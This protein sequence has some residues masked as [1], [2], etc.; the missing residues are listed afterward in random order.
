MAT[1]QMI[2]LA[3]YI[4]SY[5]KKVVTNSE[6]YEDGAEIYVVIVRF[7][8]TW[9]VNDSKDGRIS[10]TPGGGGI[11]CYTALTDDTK[12]SEMFTFIKSTVEINLDSEKRMAL[13]LEKK[14]VLTEI[15]LHYND[16]EKLKTIE[17]LVDG[18]K[19]VMTK[20]KQTPVAPAKKEE[21]KKKEP[22]TFQEPSTEPDGDNQKNA[23]K[24]ALNKVSG[25]KA[26]VEEPKQPGRK[27]AT[28]RKQASNQ[29][30]PAGG[31]SLEEVEQLERMYGYG[32][33]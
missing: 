14:N 26:K 3:D 16:Y 8:D 6:L 11:V 13:Y 10:V 28:V 4:E 7:N 12:L 24:K 30:Q 15:F 27:S 32:D 5:E 25:R 18:E 23:F 9:S 29:P 1:E 22:A 20:A 31:M 17:F 2:E 19:F 33:E 21:A